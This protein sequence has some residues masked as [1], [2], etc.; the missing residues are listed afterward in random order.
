VP[1]PARPDLPQRPVPAVPPPDML[2]SPALGKEEHVL[3]SLEDMI[4]AGTWALGSRL[5]AERRLSELLGASRNT[6]RGALRIL[7]ARGMVQ[8]HKGSGCYLCA[9]T[10]AQPAAPRVAA[11]DREDW[12][13]RLEACF[14]ILPGLAALAAERA[15]AAAVAAMEAAAVA[16]SRAILGLDTAALAREHVGFTL[17]LARAAANPVLLMVAE[18]L[19][20]KSS[21]AFSRFFD[22][23]EPDR[24]AVFSDLVRLLA[25][26]RSHDPAQARA[27]MKQRILRLCRLLAAHAG[28][29][30]SPFL[31][32]R[33]EREEGRP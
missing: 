26:V 23:P 6:V 7:E 30:F 8:I 13:A 29:R 20:A 3:G 25:A 9:T 4:A 11:L 2:A 10:T 21:A 28:M 32:R 19:C 24:E 18:G 33:M 12:P 14:V 16:V 27:G 1:T 15:D 22:F 31:T 5:P 17:A